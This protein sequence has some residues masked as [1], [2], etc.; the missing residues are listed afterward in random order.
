ME[1]VAI[2]PDDLISVVLKVFIIVVATVLHFPVGQAAIHGESVARVLFVT[3]GV[4]VHGVGDSWG[5]WHIHRRHSRVD[6]SIKVLQMKLLQGEKATKHLVWN[7]H[8]EV[9]KNDVRQSHNH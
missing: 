5:S 3:R 7:L 8:F 1:V 4:I 6:I 9:L 2:V